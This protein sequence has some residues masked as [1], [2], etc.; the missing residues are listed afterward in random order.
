M[1]HRDGGDH[2]PALADPAGG[3]LVVFAWRVSYRRRYMHQS[4]LLLR[5]GVYEGHLYPASRLSLSDALE[6]RVTYFPGVSHMV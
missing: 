6:V 4:K 5:R 2:R 1:D 3:V